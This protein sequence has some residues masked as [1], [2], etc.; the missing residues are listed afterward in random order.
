MGCE[1]VRTPLG[2]GFVC[3]RGRRPKTCRWCSRPSTKLCDWKAPAAART[4]DAP[5]CDDHAKVVG[6]NRDHCPD[7]VA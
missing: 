2:A 7:H 6:P 4:C 3:S 1:V 5:I